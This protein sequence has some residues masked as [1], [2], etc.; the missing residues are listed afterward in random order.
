MNDLDIAAMSC[1][2][3][4]KRQM[5]R[6]ILLLS[7]FLTCIAFSA[8]AE[9]PR[10]LGAHVHGHGRLNIVIEEKTLFVELEVPAADIVG[11]EHEPVT[12]E[13]K[14]ALEK[15]K[16]KLA[17]A[18]SLFTPSPAAECTLKS[19]EVATDIERDDDDENET[20]EKKSHE[21]AG[22]RHS[23]FQA[24][25]SLEC[26][27]S[28]QITAITFDYFKAFPNAESLEVLLIFPKGTTVYDVKRNKPS[29]D[30]TGIM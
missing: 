19:A 7:G 5:A 21:E 15:G 30:L 1:A 17:D 27:S 25:Y 10:Q 24:D 16:A 12:P 23:E 14:A 29:L 18:L 28:T 9:E 8:P 3:E 26:V 13:D 22:N 2:F 20:A 4:G 6:K 11:F